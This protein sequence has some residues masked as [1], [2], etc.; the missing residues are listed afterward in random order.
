[1]GESIVYKKCPYCPGRIKIEVKD[2]K[3][4]I[5]KCNSCGYKPNNA[6]QLYTLLGQSCKI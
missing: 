3:T 4:E 2:A 1:M 6:C 5:T